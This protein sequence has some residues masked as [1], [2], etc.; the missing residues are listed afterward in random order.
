MGTS[1]IKRCQ[2]KNPDILKGGLARKALMLATILVMQATAFFAGNI[3]AKDITGKV[4]SATDNEPLIGA[5][6]QVEGSQGGTITD[7]DGNYTIKANDGQTLVFSYIGYV[8]K[9]V[10]VKGNV[11][12]IS[13]EEDGKSLEEVVVIGYGTMKKKLVT[14]ATTQLKGDDIQKLNTTNPLAA[15]QGQTPGV[16]I[17]S[18]SGQPGAS[19]SVTIRGLGTVGNSQPLYLIDGIG[20][21]ITTLNPADIER[22]DVLKDAASAAIYGAQ[23]ANGVVLVTTKSGKE[24][25]S[26]ITYDGYVGWQTV[27]RKFK[28]LNA[29][30]YM[31][32][33]DEARLNS[34]MSP[35][36]WTS[37]NSIH[38][39]NGNIYDTDWIDQAIEDGALTTS[40]SLAFTGGSK[41]ST[42]VV[43][44]GYTGQDGVIGG[45]DVSNY[46]RFNFRANSEHKMYNGLVTIG[47]RVSFVWKTQRGMGTGNIWNNNLRSAFSSSPIHPV[48][49]QNG[50]YAST[51]NSDWNVNDGNPYGNMMVNRF[52]QSK[53]G[54]LDAN[55]YMQIEPIKNLKIKTV[56]G[57]SYGTSD[58]RSFTPEYQFTPQSANTLTK[59]NQSNGN[60]L[61]MVWTNTAQYDFTLKGGH[62]FSALV[63]SEWSRYNGSSSGGYNDSLIPGFGDWEHAFLD[64]T[65]G[66]D[67]KRVNGAPY[68]ETR[69][70]SL[71]ARLGWSWKDRYMFNATIRADESSKFA[72]G[73][74]WGYFP[75]VSAGWT[76]SEENFMKSTKSWLDFLKLRASWGQVGNA[77]I[78]CYQYL[79]PVTTTNT[80]YNFGTDGSQSG[81][82]TGSYPSRLANEGVKWETSEQINVGID[83]RF[84]Q[85]RL[86]FTADWYIKKTKD[87]LVQAPVLAT[88]GTQGP[89]INGGDVKNTGVEIGL[90]WN[91]N[92]GKDFS[93]SVGGNFAYNHNKV[94]S[95]PTE[96]GIIHGASNQIYSNAE[97]FYR[98]ENGHA[99]GYFWGYKTAGIFQNQQEINDWIAAGNGVLQSNVQPGD[100]KYVDINRDGQINAVDK[101]DLGNGLPKYTFGFNVSLSWKGFDL[102]ANAT[103]AAGFQIAQSYRDPNSSQGNY[104]RQILDRWTGEGT[105]N[106]I[107]RVT[108]GDVGNWQFSDLY[109]Q[110]GDYIRLQN[111]TLGY[112][113][114]RLIS[115]KGISKLRL[116][117]QA[118]NLLTFT[119]YDGMDPE[120]GSYNGTNGNSSDSWVSGVDMGYYPHPRTFLV[121]MNI[122]F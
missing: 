17:V 89:V 109:L 55:V 102:S 34:G 105:S 10:K 107:P 81:W 45:S 50:D 23:A 80:N 118:Q 13:L 114:K 4:T 74:R 25:T 39:A 82:A 41:T 22:I 5:T 38:D 99:I 120:I 1:S 70:M 53:S 47:E 66:T 117:V 110:D 93:Y 46:R 94:G 116:Y 37:L 36:D 100:T 16:N 104:S 112:D 12:N 59:V 62:D 101:V 90:S 52:N 21:D 51:V 3:V 31:T 56:Y 44:G 122:A 43:S 11:I 32:I 97:E 57:I 20:G 121:G 96:D 92:I 91:D 35:V 73:H 14:G 40:H 60:G 95:I 9:K 48:Y 49:D 8:T 58:Y 83:A 30:E 108:Y 15:M 42:Y 69:G 111:L 29:N 88:A 19:M 27:G 28:M 79:A 71:F 78:N 72:P 64:N 26:K 2:G 76:I 113:F 18:T 85:S 33:M 106:R 87:W 75:S 67:N 63:G 84:I 65:N 115:W 6:V 61:S 7:F 119:K 98:A 68:D 54:N 86:S 103:G 24:G 77:N